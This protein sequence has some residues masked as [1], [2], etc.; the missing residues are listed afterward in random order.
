MLTFSKAWIFAQIFSITEVLPE[1]HRVG[2]IYASESEIISRWKK[3]SRLTKNFYVDVFEVLYFMYFLLEDK[4]NV[5]ESAQ[6]VADEQ[7]CKAPLCWGTCWCLCWHFARESIP[8]SHP[9][10]S[11]MTSHCHAVHRNKRKLKEW[12]LLLFK[13]GAFS[14]LLMF[15]ADFV[16]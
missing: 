4:L 13:V 11:A 3:S 9:N 14:G 6:W 8:L 15:V 16:R 5:A 2:D 10:V 12:V 1:I 7:G